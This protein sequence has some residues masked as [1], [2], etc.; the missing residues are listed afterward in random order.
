MKNYFLKLESHIKKNKVLFIL[1]TITLITLTYTHLNTFLSNDD[2]PYSF[3][4]RGPNR[5]TNIIEVIKNQ[6]AD[7]S[8]ING[9]IIIHSIMQTL[10]IFDKNLWSILNP[11]MILTSIICIINISSCFTKKNNKSILYMIG[12]IIFLLLSEFKS[13]IYWVAG[14]INYVWTFT[15]LSI[16]LMLYYKEKINNTYIK[17]IIIFILTALQESTMV[18]TI[19]F[20]IFNIL[21]KWNETKKFDR[22]YIFYILSLSGSLILL[23]S[24]ANQIRLVTDPMWNQMNL[25]EKLMTS[26]PVVSRNLIDLLDYKNIIGYIF[27]ITVCTNVFNKNDKKTYL[28]I[29][30]IIINLIA[31]YILKLDW[32]YFLLVLMLIV[33]E[34]YGN[35]N[36][37]RIKLCILSLSF[38]SVAYFPILTPVYYAGR[39]NY[40]F[41]MYVI[42]F[43][44]IVLTDKIKELKLKTNYIYILL[45]ILFTTL[46][47]KEII[48]YTNIG[49]IH[50]KRLQQIE[51]YKN[52]KED[53]LVLQRIPDEYSYYHMDANL[54]VKEYFTYTYFL[55]YYGLKENT[56][57]EYK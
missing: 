22:K 51:K 42:L 48:I 20:V 43:T 23:L 56:I 18:F 36:K 14:S 32:L 19:I 16:A 49:N 31:I 35:I 34:Y 3:F 2:L 5:I 12:I 45:Y 6:V 7:Y 39:P 21:Y 54:P 13:I 4:Y 15:I 29:S 27:V 1:I 47:I 25:L 37:S 57:I 53:V 46:L 33:A 8:S 52:N 55:Q 26:I 41:Y 24:P 30:L 40:F 11:I 17:C 50:S 38:Y 9:R 10:L 44:M 28:I